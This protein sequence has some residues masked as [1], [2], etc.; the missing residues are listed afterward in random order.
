MI[1]HLTYISVLL[2]GVI[3]GYWL[4]ELADSIQPNY[5]WVQI[6]NESGCELAAASIVF[7]DRTTSASKEQIGSSRY[8]HG[9]ESDINIPVLASES[10]KYHVSLSFSDCPT[11][12]GEPQIVKSGSLI[13]VFVGKSEIRY[14]A[15]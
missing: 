12:T 8:P 13:Q 4:S 1:K 10:D 9:G 14:G 3:A 6:H 7:P 5:R 15:R 11:R 2:V